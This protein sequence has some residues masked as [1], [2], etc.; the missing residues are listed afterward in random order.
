[1][2]TGWAT[3]DTITESRLNRTDWLGYFGAVPVDTGVTR[4]PV[5]CIKLTTSL[6]TMYTSP[7]GAGKK[8]IIET[9]TLCNTDGTDR[10]TEVHIV[11]SGGS[12]AAGNQIFK[13]TIKAGETVIL[14]GP[15]LLDPSDFIQAKAAAA[16]VVIFRAEAAEC[17]ADPAGLTLFV[18]DGAALTTGAVTYYTATGDA[19]VLAVTICNTSG[20]DDA[21][22]VYIIQSGGTASD[23]ETVFA[24]T[25]KAGETVIL[26]GKWHLQDGDFIQALGATGAVHGFRV[27]AVEFA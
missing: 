4:T 9:I 1:M 8:S 20:S 19:F 21:V 26:G 23:D 10:V 27:T 15:W 11:E 16:D 14:D 6:V 2:A 25:V 18:D 17:A 24:D 5:D 3:S 7:A 12:A 22:T 13:D